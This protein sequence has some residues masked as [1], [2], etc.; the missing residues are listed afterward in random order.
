LEFLSSMNPDPKH[1]RKD[2]IP[3]LIGRPLSTV[4]VLSFKLFNGVYRCGSTSK[5]CLII[6]EIEDISGAYKPDRTPG[7]VP[8]TILP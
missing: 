7:T 3:S 2:L 1:A 8:G 4:F 5:M 6:K